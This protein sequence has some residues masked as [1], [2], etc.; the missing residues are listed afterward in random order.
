MLYI[1]AIKYMCYKVVIFQRLISGKR[2]TKYRQIWDDDKFLMKM[3]QKTQNMNNS[4]VN[5][6]II[7]RNSNTNTSYDEDTR[8]ALKKPQSS[9]N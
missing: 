3:S 5:L 1:H 8:K 7:R 6:V 4:L 2:Y 9:L